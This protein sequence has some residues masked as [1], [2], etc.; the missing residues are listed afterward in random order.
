MKKIMI[1]FLST[2]ITY[3]NVTAQNVGIGT[4]TPTQ[5]L[6]VTGNLRVSGAIM[7]GGTAGTAG[8]VLTSNGT[9]VA[10][11]WENFAMAGGGRFRISLN[12][13]T[14][15]AL[16][17]TRNGFDVSGATSQEDSVDF[18]TVTVTGTDFTIVSTGTTGNTITINRT[19]LYHFEGAIRLVVNSDN[20]VE[21][22]PR[23]VVRF[24]TTSA[25]PPSNTLLNEDLMELTGSAATG[26]GGGRFLYNYLAKFS[27][28]IQ[29]TAG[30]QTAFVA[31]FSNLRYPASTPLVALGQL[32]NSYISG[33]FISE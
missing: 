2:F 21:L 11:T 30:T 16:A 1:I 23:G 29:L 26:S 8:Q 12:N 17:N 4:T 25:G 18:F 32:L 6:D 13:N 15:Q 28:N 10:P 24:M 3:I 31:G 27:F 14:G 9:G 7:P 20:T 5:K 22:A 19:G 33:Y